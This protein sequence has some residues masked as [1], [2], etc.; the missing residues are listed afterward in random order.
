MIQ[1]ILFGLVLVVSCSRAQA[2]DLVQFENDE[3]RDYTAAE[4][5][6]LLGSDA[7]YL[8]QHH[9]DGKQEFQLFTDAVAENLKHDSLRLMDAAER[10]YIYREG[11]IYSSDVGIEVTEVTD[12]FVSQALRAL[13]LLEKK[14]SAARL[15]RE[16]EK[17]RY[18]IYVAKGGNRFDP[19][20]EGGRTGY[21]LLEAQGLIYFN[22]LRKPDNIL[23]F[24]QLGVGGIVRWD[25]NGNYPA[26]E[27][28][29]VLRSTPPEVAL[30]HELYHSY[31]SIRGLLDQ[32]HVSGAG[33]EFEPVVEYR[34]VYFENQIRAES[35]LRYRRSYDSSLTDPKAD[36]LLDDAGKP[37]LIPA[38]CLR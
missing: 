31:D 8:D 18:R 12:P 17:S 21:G 20:E 5:T 29:N 35:G 38:A 19:R 14:P 33:Y 28:D 26:L 37:I 13:N 4:L 30:A 24:H 6:G 7:V 9:C 23:P 3:F 2:Y 11:K 27:S 36:D 16:L 1:K 10:N 34:G 15:I 32:R 22:T 25:P